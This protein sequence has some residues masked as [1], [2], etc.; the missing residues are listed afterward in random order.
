MNDTG[1]SSLQFNHITHRLLL[2]EN[3]GR[4]RYS[5]PEILCCISIC[6]ALAGIVYPVQ[7]HRPHLLS[8]DHPPSPSLEVKHLC[9]Q[10]WAPTARRC[11]VSFPYPAFSTF[12]SY[13]RQIASTHRPSH[14]TAL[15]CTAPHRRS[16]SP[17]AAPQTRLAGGGQDP[18]KLSAAPQR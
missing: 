3:K 9:I 6:L 17:D 8:A 1:S 11:T 16:V 14:C 7:S 13:S 4:L 2:T 10:L 5:V 18:H 12:Y 15:H